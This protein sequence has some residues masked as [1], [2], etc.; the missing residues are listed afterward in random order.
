MTGAKRAEIIRG[1]PFDEQQ[2]WDVIQAAE[3]MADEHDAVIAEDIQYTKA[4]FYYQTQSYSQSEQEALKGLEYLQQGGEDN[5]IYLKGYLDI[6]GLLSKIYEGMH[7][8]PNALKYEK[9]KNDTYREIQRRIRLEIVKGLEI[10]NDTKK[11]DGE[12]KTL[13]SV[14]EKDSREKFLYYIIILLIVIIFILA[15]I[16]N[17][18]R[19][20]L[21]NDKLEL[22]RL[23]N[24]E[25]ENQINQLQFLTLRSKFIPHFTGNVL[26]SINYLTAHDQNSAQKYIAKFGVFLNQTLLNANHLSRTLREELDYVGNYLDLEKLR[27]EDAL[28][29]HIEV[30]PEVDTGMQ[31]PTMILQTLSENAIKHGLKPNNGT[32]V[33]KI[34]AR[35][36]ENFTVI[37][38]EDNGI[39]RAAAGKKSKDIS[40]EGMKIVEQQLE[41]YRKTQSRSCSFNIIDLYDVSN[42][43]SGTRCEVIVE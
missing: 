25:T 28:E 18:R 37:S 13:T 8:Y 17:K 34:E 16:L 1:K 35:K 6:Y 7:N 27:Y 43:A 14:V 15:V 2:V 24:I 23:Q 39:G 29:Y 36:R 42:R 19:I 10:Q 9:L 30:N 4:I 33:I 5:K 38:V 11:K 22:H 3:L 21:L 40:G 12:I 41:M 32:G 31:I 26:N 20:G